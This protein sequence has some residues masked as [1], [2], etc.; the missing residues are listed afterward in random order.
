VEVFNR[1]TNAFSRT[2]AVRAD[3]L[4]G[5]RRLTTVMA[6]LVVTMNGG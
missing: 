6:T 3:G 4:P 1:T 5:P 2:L